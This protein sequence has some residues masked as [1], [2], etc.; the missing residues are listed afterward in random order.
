M[1]ARNHGSI[2]WTLAWKEKKGLSRTKTNFQSG[3]NFFFNSLFKSSE[4]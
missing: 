2:G 1:V 4:F 3:D